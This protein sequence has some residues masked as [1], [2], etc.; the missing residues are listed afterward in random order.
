MKY[1]ILN[2]FIVCCLIF[3]TWHNI[4]TVFPTL[5]PEPPKDFSQIAFLI[6]LHQRWNMFAPYPSLENYWL[7]IPGRLSNNQ[8]VDLFY[9]GQ[10][11]SYENPFYSNKHFQDARWAKYLSNLI[12]NKGPQ[13]ENYAKY[14]CRKWNGTHG[15]EEQLL[16]MKFYLMQQKISLDGKEE[17]VSKSYFF[18]WRCV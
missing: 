2:G 18:W 16:D 8:Y 15:K 9:Y 4:R 5:I 11:V 7:V 17:P 1:F 14:L 13:Y 3:I 12:A 10:P 6:G